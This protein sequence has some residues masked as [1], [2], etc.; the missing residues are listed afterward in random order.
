MIPNRTMAIPVFDEVVSA[1]A[2]HRREMRFR[3]RL[4]RN[5]PMTI[6]LL[7]D[8][9]DDNP[10][11]SITNGI[12][13]AVG[14]VLQRWPEINPARLVIVEH[15]DDRLAHTRASTRARRILETGRENG[16]SFDLVTFDAAIERLREVAVGV[17][18]YEPIWKHTTKTAVEDLIGAHLP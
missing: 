11:L 9:G 6:A 5:E 1:M 10:G 16:E 12:E 8:L 17:R 15:Y 3:A 18:R 4:F 2:F 14:A 13:Y 7:T